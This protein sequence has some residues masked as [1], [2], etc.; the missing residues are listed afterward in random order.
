MGFRVWTRKK[1]SDRG[2][3]RI[4]QILEVGIKRVRKLISSVKRGGEEG[5][6]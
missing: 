6:K 4:T 5:I 1:E 2:K 3:Y